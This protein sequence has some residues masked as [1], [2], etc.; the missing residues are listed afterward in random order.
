MHQR[1]RPSAN[2]I[3]QN[4]RSALKKEWEAIDQQL[5]ELQRI[6]LNSAKDIDIN[7]SISKLQHDVNEFL[8]KKANIGLD[9][10]KN[11]LAGSDAI[12]KQLELTTV[13]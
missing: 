5:K 1:Q 6:Q 12:K 10:T 8:K 11:Q 9:A 2:W 3:N 4:C 13:H 7:R